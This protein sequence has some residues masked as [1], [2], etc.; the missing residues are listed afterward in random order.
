MEDYSNEYRDK[1]RPEINKRLKR[2]FVSFIGCTVI[3]IVS[4]M[5]LDFFDLPDKLIFFIFI[6]CGVFYL[7]EIF[8]FKDIKCP[9]CDKSLF[10]TSNIGKVPI[11]YRSYVSVKCPHCGVKL[12]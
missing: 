2:I 4:S 5:L 3:L 1:I 8:S 12:R 11:I 9:H 6:P 7:R 10:T